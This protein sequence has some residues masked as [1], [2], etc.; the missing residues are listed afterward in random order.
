MSEPL[1][2]LRQVAQVTDTPIAT[3]RRWVLEQR[4]PVERVGPL[5]LKRVRV[6]HSVLVELFPHV[7]KVTHS[8]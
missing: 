1:Y 7:E 6:R 5:R 4:I 3:V 2:S 8:A